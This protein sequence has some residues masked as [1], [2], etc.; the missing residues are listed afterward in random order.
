MSDYP[1]NLRYTKDHEWARVNGKSVVVGITRFAVEQL[2]DITQVELPNEGDT[3]AKGEIFG[4]VDSV[5]TASDLYAPVS[6]TIV[7]T[8]S[9]LN[10]SPEN[11]NE[12]TYDEG[13]LIE[14]EASDEAQLKELM[15]AEAYTKFLQE[16]DES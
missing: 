7:R 3:I 16:L 2:S 5:K 1:A 12:D 4:S 8:N 11:I 9:V 10:D 15:D 6:G 14:I 13:W